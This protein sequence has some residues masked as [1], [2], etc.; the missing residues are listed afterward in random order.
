MMKKGLF[1]VMIISL[2]ILSSCSNSG[3]GEL[4]GVSNRKPFFEPQ[5]YGMVLVPRGSFN[6]GPS[7]QDVVWANNPVKTV[8]VDA[9]WM[10]ETEITNNEYRQFVFWVRDSIARRMLG[11]QFPEFSITEDDNGN[12]IDP[13]RLNWDEEIE[14]RS[15]EFADA[16]EELYYPEN[17]RMFNRREIDPRKMI[18]EYYWID[19]QQAARNSGKFNQETGKYE[20]TVRNSEGELVPIENRTSFI[21]H[22]KVMI[23]PDTLCWIKNFTYSYNEPWVNMYF[24][25]PGFDDY[26]VVGVNWHQAK[27]FCAWRTNFQNDYLQSVDEA[28]V[29]Q[30][31]LP[32]EAEWEYAAR[33]GLD[34][35]MYPWGGY[36]TRTEGGCFMANFKPL[37]G[38]YSQDGGLATVK[39]MSYDPNGYGLYDMAGNVAEWTVTAYDEA[40]S[41][42]MNEFN[43]NY[44]YN[45]LPNDPPSMKRK[46]IRG[47]SWKDIAYFLQTGTRTYQ[48]Q[49][50]AKSYIG[51]RCVRSSFGNEF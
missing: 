50:S 39:V 22:D 13:P 30:Y 16:L 46:V 36:Y 25:H 42:L 21:M 20:G 34:M 33:G 26:P 44:E 38:N 27:A 1:F 49:D 12:I 37:R 19:Y 23:Y 8:S 28:G 32:S 18:Y 14:W 45:A 29:Q 43:P 4:T 10:D 47:G 24:W 17:E 11:D 15:P 6:M 3:N 48:Y 9:F 35:S 5:P 41:S 31:R 40:S 2:F 51:F 7:D